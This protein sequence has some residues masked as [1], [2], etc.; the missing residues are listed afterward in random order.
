MAH[1]PAKEILSA[2][3][4]EAVN[5]F[6]ALIEHGEA[7]GRAASLIA[8]AL[9]AGHTLLICGNGGS[10]ADASHI[11]AEIVG[12]F[13]KE[14]RGYAAIALSDSPAA[15]TAISNDYGFDQVFARQVEAFGRAGDVLLAISTSGNSPN[16]LAAM[17][18]AKRTGLSIVTLLGKDGGKAKGVADVEMI[19]RNPV[20]ARVQEAHQLLY[21][22][23]CEALDVALV[24]G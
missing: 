4:A 10:A 12:R 22:S 14:R 24:D 15:L 16:V 20:T 5:T 3:L 1:D 19:V 17:A 9:K 2:N 6:Q 18:Q 23:L 11:A 7:L 8:D 21:H 13:V